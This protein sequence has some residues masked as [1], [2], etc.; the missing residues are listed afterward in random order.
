MSFISSENRN[1]LQVLSLEEHI[2]EYSNVRIIDTFIESVD[3][4]NLGFIIK[5]K[6]SEG[7][8]AFDAVILCKLYL[9]GYLNGI[10]SSRK[11]DKACKVNIELWWL[12]HNQKP[13]YK[14]IADFR[15]NNQKGFRN[16]FNV[17]RQFCISLDLYGKKI[18]AIDGSKFRGQNSMKN[19]YN[20]RKIDKQ[21]DYL[22]QQYDD[23]SKELDRNDNFDKDNKI[24]NKLDK[25]K[26]K[27]DKL[28]QQLDA[29]Q[30]TQISTTDPDTRAL[31]LHMRIVQVGYN[32]QS[33]VDAKHK[34]I[35]E[36]DITN[37]NDHRA[38][39]PMALK[40][41]E[42]FKLNKSDKLTVLADKGYHTGE[43]LQQCHNNNISTLVAVPKRRKQNDNSKPDYLT[44]E[45]FIF[46]NKKNNYTC[47]QGH[48][49]QHQSTYRRKKKGLITGAPF[50]R[51]KMDWDTC[52]ICP[53]FEQCVSKGNKTRKQGR[54]IDRV[55]T[56]DAIVKNK[57]MVSR[58]KKLYRTR[59]EIVEHPFGTIKR[60]WGYDH[61]LMK[62][63]PKVHTEFSIITLC[64][65]IRR[66]MSIMGVNQLINAMKEAFLFICSATAS[67]KSR[68][69]N[70]ILLLCLT[71]HKFT[72]LRTQK[73]SG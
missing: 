58:R 33:S 3:V 42:A 30:E 45:N 49:L 73:I 52:R 41:R 32:L 6:S 15:K 21:L 60:Q 37:K 25:R 70:F 12:L 27:Y 23:Y 4:Q 54:Y 59:Q 5:G 46:D 20:Q 40:T 64:Y 35:A 57:R 7:R 43:Q 1:Q 38:L 19:N 28:Q 48:I 65:N 2:A 10:R 56:D 68:V 69:Y 39:A 16:L 53:H 22:N 17:F 47:P 36:F 51:Y 63:T 50:D 72:Y 61:T 18:V 24:K 29:T 66:T 31:P 44:K 9:Y 55:L 34:L 62:T 67:V 71:S 11:L 26:D 13:G 8:P 14:T